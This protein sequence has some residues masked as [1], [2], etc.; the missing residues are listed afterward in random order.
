DAARCRG[1][2]SRRPRGRRRERGWRLW[3]GS[4][5]SLLALD[6]AW[7]IRWGRPGLRG[8]RGRVPDGPR[9]PRSTLF[10]LDQEMRAPV[11]SPAG[12]ALLVANRALFAVADDRD[13]AGLDAES[14]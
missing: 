12:F 11:P 14:H 10:G 7:I 5:R 6:S 8:Q 1:P 9:P 3:A 4:S 2:V 13:S